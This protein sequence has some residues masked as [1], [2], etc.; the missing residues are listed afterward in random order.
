MDLAG[1]VHLNLKF[2]ELVLNALNADGTAHLLNEIF[3]NAQPK[4]D[5]VFISW[6]ILLNPAEVEEEVVELVGGYTD[7]VIFDCNYE[8]DEIFFAIFFFFN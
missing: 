2:S 5:S 6:G 4:S 1:S 8:A 3:A 7:S